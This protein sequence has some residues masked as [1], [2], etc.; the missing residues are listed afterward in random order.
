MQRQSYEPN[1]KNLLFNN[2]YDLW[3]KL[4]SHEQN[5]TQKLTLIFILIRQPQCNVQMQNQDSRLKNCSIKKLF[6]IKFHSM[7]IILIQF[8][9]N[10]KYYIINIFNLYTVFTMFEGILSLELKKFIQY[11]IYLTIKKTHNFTHRFQLCNHYNTL[12]CTSMWAVSLTWSFVKIWILE[13]SLSQP[14]YR[15][16]LPITDIN[17]KQILKVIIR[18]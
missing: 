6:T 14:H 17:V 4:W 8:F 7:K 15:L 11:R 13:S 5:N 16:N 2:Y 12:H 18:T 9:T 3:Q 10:S 1:E